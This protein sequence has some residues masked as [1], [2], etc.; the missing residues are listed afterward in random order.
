MDKEILFKILRLDTLVRV[1]SWKERVLIHLLM[2]NRLSGTTKKIK[3]VY[4]WIKKNNWK[5][6]LTQYGQDRLEYF[7]DFD[8]ERWLPVEE[9]LN[10]NQELKSELLKLK[11]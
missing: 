11:L 8:K 6:P 3:E 2:N 1:L 4:D 5:S 9:Y 10:H 7:Y